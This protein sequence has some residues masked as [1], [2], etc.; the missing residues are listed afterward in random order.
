MK[1]ISLWILLVIA[2]VMAG[3][4]IHAQWIVSG[5][6]RGQVLTAP[7]GSSIVMPGGTRIFTVSSGAT[8]VDLPSINATTTGTAT[9]TVTG[10]GTSDVC[11][12]DPPN[13]INDDLVPKGCIP[14]AADTLTLAVYNPTAGAIDDSSK[15]W[16]WI[17][18]DIS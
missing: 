4:Y 9:I 10:I 2:L 5:S 13:N 12:C 1:K 18:W 14:T 3:G 17:C 7:N 11:V 8:G 6:D 15:T 16:N